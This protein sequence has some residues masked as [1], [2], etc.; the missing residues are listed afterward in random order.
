MKSLKLIVLLV[1][2][3]MIFSCSNENDISTGFDSCSRCGISWGVERIMLIL[4]I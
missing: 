4:N 2:S 1:L 3:L